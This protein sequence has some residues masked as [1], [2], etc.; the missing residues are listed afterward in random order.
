MRY[1]F[2]ALAKLREP[3]ELDTPAVLTS[4]RGWLTLAAL[5]A[6][7]LAAVG[8]AVFG[9]LPRTVSASGLIARPYAAAQVQTLYPGMVTGI[10]ARVG[11]QV[12]AGQVLAVIHDAAGVSRQVV[13]VFAGQVIGIEVAQGE[14]VGAGATIVTVERSGPAA[15][16]PVALLFVSPSL[17][18]G[19]TP[20]QSVG[21]EVASAPSAAFG[22]LRGRVLSVSPFPLTGPAE[23][24]LTGGLAGPGR[25]AGAGKLLVTVHLLRDAR[26]PSGYAWT[27]RAGPP[28]ALPAVVAVTGM[29]ALGEQAPITLL[30]GR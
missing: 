5:G 8:W 2:R 21:L 14:V 19:I 24:V 11:G 15:G 25:L 16:T 22:L 1:R 3:D 29:I 6:V 30:F 20:G 28:Q 12:R 26:T 18:A 9:R 13:S 7:A 23:Q 27:T 17:A 4:P 10:R